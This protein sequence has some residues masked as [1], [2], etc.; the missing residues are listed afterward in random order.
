MRRLTCHKKET[1]LKHADDQLPVYSE[2]GL[3][4]NNVSTEDFE[5]KI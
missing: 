5:D 2:Q 4:H 1:I 3:T